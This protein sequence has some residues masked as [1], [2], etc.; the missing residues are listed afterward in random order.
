MFSIK[1]GI[2]LGDWY[3]CVIYWLGENRRQRQGELLYR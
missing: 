2:V 3:R 1:S